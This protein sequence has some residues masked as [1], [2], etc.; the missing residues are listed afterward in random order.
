MSTD[1]RYF[2]IERDE[3]WHVE[4]PERSNPNGLVF[5]AL[6]GVDVDPEAHPDLLEVD[7]FAHELDD[8]LCG[9][10]AAD[11]AARIDVEAHL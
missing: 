1:L 5:V 4:N 2:R 7:R 9:N 10:C 6:C 11:L 8:R 3:Q